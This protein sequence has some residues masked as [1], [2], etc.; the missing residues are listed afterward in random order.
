MKSTSRD[1]EVLIDKINFQNAFDPQMPLSRQDS[2][3]HNSYRRKPNQGDRALTN[4]ERK[5]MLNA[6]RGDC[7]SVAKI[8]ELNNGGKSDI[9]D[10]NCKDP[11][12]RTA[13][14]IA[15]INE[16]PELMD[17]L[18]EAGI[19]TYDSL[20]LAIDEEYVEGVEIL[21]ECE[22]RVW[23]QGS[24]HSWE[25]VDPVHASYTPD[26]TPL[27]LSAHKNNYEILK[28][29]LDRG[30]ILPKLHDI[31][32]N[33]EACL[34]SAKQDSLRFSLSRLNSYKA[35]ASPSLIALTS[36]DPIFT[37]FLLSEQLKK[38]SKMESQYFKEYTILR[39]Q[40]QSFATSLLDHARSSYEL[41]VMLNYD[42][43]RTQWK[44]GHH[45][46]LDRLKMAI[47]CKQKS[48]V[49]HPNVQ[50]L[51]SS[52]WYEGVPGFRRKNIFFQSVMIAK[53]CLLYPFYCTMYMLLPASKHGIYIK[54]PFIKFICHSSSYIFFLMLLAMASQRIE[55][56]IVEVIGTLFDDQDMYNLAKEWERKERGS[57]PSH[58]ETMIILWQICL[59]WRDMKVVYQMGV[60]EYIN[61]LWNLADWFTN[62]CFLSWIILRFTS[63]Y[64]VSLEISEGK[65][66]YIP[67]EDWETYDPYLISEGLFGAGM[68]SSYLKIVQI[69]S[70]NPHLGPLQISLG[71][72]IMDICKWVSL[73]GLVLFAFACGM[74]QLLWYY[75]A[76]EK[77]QCDFRSTRAKNAACLVWRRF[78]NL[79]ETSQTLF[80]AVFG[81]V[82]FTD[83][84]LTGLKD[85]TRF[86][87]LLMFGCYSTCNIIVLLNMLIAMMS[88]SYQ[89]ISARSDKEWKFARTKLWMSYFEAGSTLPP[90]FNI[91]PTVKSMVN[92]CQRVRGHGKK[93][94]DKYKGA[95]E[96]VVRHQEIMCCIVKRYIMSEQKRAEEFGI[97]EDDVSEI[98]QDINKFR[99]EL[100]EILRKNQF[101]IGNAGTGDQCR[102]GKRAKQMERRILK[103]FNI[104]IHDLVKDVFDK[105]D[106]SK[107]VDIFQVMAEA[108]HKKNYKSTPA[109][110]HIKF[111]NEGSIDYSPATILAAKKFK[112][113]LG[114]RLKPP[115]RENTQD[116][117]Q[118]R[119]NDVAK[120][121]MSNPASPFT[122]RGILA[123]AESLPSSPA[124]HLQKG[125]RGSQMLSSSAH[126]C[127][128]TL[129]V[130]TLDAE[131]PENNEVGLC[132]TVAK[133]K[134]NNSNLSE[135]NK[136]RPKIKPYAIK[137]AVNNGEDLRKRSRTNAAYKPL[138]NMS[139]GKP[140]VSDCQS[141]NHSSQMKN[142][143][144]TAE[145]CSKLSMVHKPDQ[146]TSGWI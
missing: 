81:L 49:A 18:L 69:L 32:C 96:A 3:D 61:D 106:K 127:T 89:T 126:P 134:G 8:V 24:P 112:R 146:V 101:D 94:S 53:L 57:L 85:F 52:I 119:S 2:R 67:R 117:K 6:E 4:Q 122:G 71:R 62:V 116:C 143:K 65:D 132:K 23:D 125:R 79:F 12:G 29:L 133:V 35:L 128:I 5:F 123:S 86:W 17:I 36:S 145:L 144:R 135:T 37:A 105:Q 102:G 139:P 10:I 109:L 88:A 73:C 107:T 110:N 142:S 64:L 131:M 56:L 25:A 83:F 21:L 72:M 120:K 11:L 22:E 115:T 121:S 9:F 44:P 46:T 87:A 114:K 42:G 39:D 20:L 93:L 26:I 111:Q 108:I 54:N 91:L 28:I 13:L 19:K 47:K 43:D 99:F 60:V 103:G 33:C 80:W 129:N 41:E 40:V 68:I 98:R 76:L 66:P 55:Y 50:Q 140:D 82:N 78:S 92:I 95:D 97:T 27:I 7:A 15:I 136:D 130:P 30:A 75:A 113:Y 74:N 63:C 45:Q 48:F 77:S 104:D 70:V 58:V 100:I 124:N 51:L 141:N 1:S 84:E 138:Q 14:S 137:D 16:N 31:K 90:P 59:L 34:E 38:L 118:S